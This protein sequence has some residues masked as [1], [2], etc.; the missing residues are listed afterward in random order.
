[1]PFFLP[2]LIVLTNKVSYWGIYKIEL[3]RENQANILI[4]NS[5]IGFKNI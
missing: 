5:T 3:S 4:L 1:M 2:K